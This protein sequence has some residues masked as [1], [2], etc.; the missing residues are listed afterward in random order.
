M[1]FNNPSDLA[2][3]VFTLL[4]AVLLATLADKL[5][6]T[7][8]RWWGRWQARRR[9]TP[10]RRPMRRDFPDAD[11]Q[12]PYGKGQTLTSQRRH[13]DETLGPA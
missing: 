11:D 8:R 4:I 2:V 9:P 5:V 1:P 3:V 6:W 12:A 10:P 13:N 7:C